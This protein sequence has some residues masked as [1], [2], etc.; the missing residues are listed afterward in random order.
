MTTFCFITVTPPTQHPESKS[1]AI[2]QPTGGHVQSQLE[3]NDTDSDDY[4][5]KWDQRA[6]TSST[7]LEKTDKG[8]Y[9][10]VLK[11]HS[12]VLLNV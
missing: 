11:L 4:H 12:K 7:C 10:C 3:K 5:L 8:Q 6:E 1:A 2:R 9:K